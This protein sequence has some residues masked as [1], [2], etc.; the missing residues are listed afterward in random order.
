MGAWIPT[1]ILDDRD[2][3]PVDKILYAVIFNLCNERG[4]CWA[5]NEYLA[6][7][8]GI[9]IATVTRSINSLKKKGVILDFYEINDKGRFRRLK[10]DHSMTGGSNQNDLNPSSKRLEG[11]NQN[12][13]HKKT[14]IS[15]TIEENNIS[16]DKQVMDLIEELKNKYVPNSQKKPFKNTPRRRNSIR[17]CVR[18]FKQQWPGRD[19]LKACRY[20]FEYKAKEWVG[21]VMWKYFVP[22]TLFSHFVE[23]LEQAEQNNG[24]P[25]MAAFKN[26]HTQQQNAVITHR[27]QGTNNQEQLDEISRRMELA[28]Q[29]RPIV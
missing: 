8:L 27:A 4:Y 5:S 12:D 25:T 18:D 22:E 10:I 15:N 1:F 26:N 14:V 13:E 20:A 7:R 16:L 24:I 11:S 19:F 28:K 3:N 2:L 23:Y 9:G 29:K 17:K 21:T 6:D